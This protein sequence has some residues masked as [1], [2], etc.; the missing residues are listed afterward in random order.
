MGLRRRVDRRV[1]GE[2]D[3]VLADGDQVAADREIIDG[4]PVVLGVDDRRRFGGKPRQILIDAE[5]GDVESAGRK[6][7]S[8]TGVAS[9]PAR[10]SSLASSKMR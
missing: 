10:T 8:V 1:V 7:F 4:A 3:H 5:P 2:V 9:L 6:V